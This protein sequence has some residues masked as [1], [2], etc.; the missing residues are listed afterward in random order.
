MAKTKLKL[1][2]S[3]NHNNLILIYDTEWNRYDIWVNGEIKAKIKGKRPNST[4]ATSLK[5]PKKQFDKNNYPDEIKKIQNIIEETGI[6]EK[7]Q[8]LLKDLISELTANRKIQE[9]NF[10]RLN[11]GIKTQYFNENQLNDDNSSNNNLHDGIL[12]SKEADGFYLSYIDYSND[13]IVFNCNENNIKETRWEFEETPNELKKSLDQIIEENPNYEFHDL[14]NDSLK[15]ILHGL[16]NDKPTLDALINDLNEV[17]NQTFK[18]KNNTIRNDRINNISDALMEIL[19]N[20]TEKI[21]NNDSDYVSARIKTLTMEIT[22][23]LDERKNKCVEIGRR[24]LSLLLTLK[25]GIILRKYIGTIYKVNGN[26]YEPTSHDDLIIELTKLFGANYI[27]DTDLK[28]AIGYISKRIEPVPNIV[29]FENTLF[30]MDKL[31]EY[32]PTNP[33]FTVLNIPY[34]YNS[35][36]KSTMFEKFLNT[37][38]ERKTT[39]ETEQAVKGIKQLCGY[40]FTSGNSSMIIP[41][42]TGLTGAGKTTFLNI[43]TGI[44]GKDKISGISL[45]SLENDVHASSGFIGKHL[46]IISDSDTTIIKNNSII[47]NWTGNEPYSVNPKFK[48]L[49]NLPAEEVPK[50]ILACNTMPEFKVYDDAIIRRFAIVEFLVSMTKKGTAIKD[51]DKKILANAE[52]VEWFIYESIQAYKDMI[53]NDEEFIF[54]ISDEETKELIEKHT[55]PINHIIQMLIL[56]HDPRAYKEE[57]DADLKNEFRPVFTDE[58]VEAILFISDSEGID[59]PVNKHGKIDKKKLLNVIRDEY[60]LHDGEIVYNKNTGTFS[61][62]RDYTARQERFNGL[63]KK[64]YPNLIATDEYFEILKEVQKIKKTNKQD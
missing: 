49:F 16:E 45:Q 23:L 28:K 34:K 10:N 9:A 12:I 46:N 47:K 13:Y 21:L 44:F 59:V 56:K 27:H 51:L 25:Y 22:D 35:N 52:E 48:D 54:K 40:F 60:D 42:F 20:E 8:F 15:E 30:D 64:C 17:Y 50:P 3:A 37:T 61:N 19:I 43:L 29:K 41:I 24:K 57:K 55:H 11:H 31:E 39:S 6:E 63:N 33:I 4:L 5:I 62:H 2:V 26:G 1:M 38:F 7:N 18:E 14:T 53:N 58:L 32:T 36:A